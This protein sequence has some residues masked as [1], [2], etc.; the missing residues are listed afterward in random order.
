MQS[1]RGHALRCVGLVLNSASAALAGDITALT[2]ADVLSKVL[3]VPILDGLGENLT[4]L[5]PEWRLML[6]ATM[7]S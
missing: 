7:R 2:N 1:V 5:P 4:E 3:D 6:E